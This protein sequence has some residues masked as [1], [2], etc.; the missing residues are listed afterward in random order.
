MNLLKISFTLLCLGLF[1]FVSALEAPSNI[2]LDVATSNSLGIYW[3]NAEWAEVYSISYWKESWKINWYEFEWELVVW[4]DAKVLI[5][6]LNENTEYFIGIMSYDWDNNSSE[7][8]EEVSFSTLWGLEDLKINNLN[9]KDTRTSILEF[10]V[11]LDADWL[12][13][14]I[15]SNKNDDL[16]D[17]EIEKYTVDWNKLELF[18]VEDLRFWAK[19][20]V[21]IIT[22]DWVN[23]EKINAW[24]DWIVDFD[25]PEDTLVYSEDNIDNIDLNVATDPIL[26]ENTDEDMLSWNEV[27]NNVEEKIIEAVA[28][29]TEALPT[30]W[31]AETFLFLLFSLIAGGLFLSL[32]RRTNA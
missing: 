32:R 9:L 19:Y 14:A 12:I 29:E 8:S 2:N 1:N 7:Y 26:D 23:G 4:E 5:E 20:S 11:D 3:D 22:L 13:N 18:F 21:T 15:I 6:N 31:P 17:I 30:T 16:E 24:V 27:E 10:N 28:K 25:I